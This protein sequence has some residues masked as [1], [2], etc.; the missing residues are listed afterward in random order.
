LP[1]DYRTGDSSKVRR[2]IYVDDRVFYVNLNLFN[3]LTW[4]RARAD[5]NLITLWIDAICI[6]QKDTSERNHQ[7]SM[8]RHIYGRAACVK[9]WLG[10][11]GNMSTRAFILA[12]DLA[13]TVKTGQ[14]KS[15]FNDSWRV[16]QFAAFQVLLHREYWKRIWVIQEVNAAK[17]AKVLCGTVSYLWNRI[18]CAHFIAI[19]YGSCPSSNALQTE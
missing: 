16:D 11:G 18:S 8:M 10:N 17:E 12:R 3:A 2:A 5:S 1:T 19:L 4:L 7:V 14:E 9:I 15:L 6:N 13:E